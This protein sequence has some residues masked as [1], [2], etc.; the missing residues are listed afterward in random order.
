[1]IPV[2]YKLPNISLQGRLQF[3]V[4]HISICEGRIPC[5]LTIV[6]TLPYTRQTH[7]IC[8]EWEPKSRACFSYKT[9]V[10]AWW[11]VHKA[12]GNV[13]CVRLENNACYISENKTYAINSS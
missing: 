10:N 6:H 2:C 7:H 4:T 1:M 9:N 11:I 8:D 12:Y 5:R 13:D 3:N